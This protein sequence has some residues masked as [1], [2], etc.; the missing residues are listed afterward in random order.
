MITLNIGAGKINF[1]DFQNEEDFIVYLDRSYQ[2]GVN[3]NVY[4]VEVALNEWKDDPTKMNHVCCGCDIF[5]FMDSF[6]FKFDHIIAY[7]I[8]EHMEYCS[9]E[10][11]RL[12]EACNMLS[13]DD[14]TMDIIVPNAHKLAEMVLDVEEVDLEH[15]QLE[16]K[17]LIINTEFCNVRCDPH[18]SVWTPKLTE[19]YIV[20]EDSWKIR[21]IKEQYPYANRNIYMRIM[22]YKGEGGNQWT[23]FLEEEAKKK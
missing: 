15:L 21:E 5:E 22:C 18:L 7:R 1:E 17:K 16:S 8:F 3:G 10:I 19:Q 11:G 23:T 9:G 13:T 6:K 12:L 2:L 14:A 4:H 20:V